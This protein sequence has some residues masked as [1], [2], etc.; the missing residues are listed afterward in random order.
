[1]QFPLSLL[2]CL[3]YHE[4]I[5]QPNLYSI[6]HDDEPEEHCHCWGG[7][8]PYNSCLLLLAN[9]S[10]ATGHIGRFLTEAV[11]STGIHT[12]TALCR[13]E[14]ERALPSGVKKVQVDFEDKN[15]LVAALKGQQFLVVSLP[16]TAPPGLNS[17]IIEAAAD[18]AVSYVMPNLYG[19][20]IRDP[21]LRSDIV[22]SWLMSRVESMAL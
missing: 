10:Q 15:S 17:R 4:I 5:C 11:A 2:F 18:A 7:P 16:M 6:P 21:K 20:D 19:A 1:M 12:V 9:R 13:P 3:K 14:S 22:R 8:F